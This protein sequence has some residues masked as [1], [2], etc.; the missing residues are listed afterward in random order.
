MWSWRRMERISWTVR[1]K[2]KKCYMESRKKGS[3]YIK[4]KERKVNWTGH[5]LNRKSLLEHVI[6]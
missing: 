2:M 5:V 1:V 3:S 4:H 6:E